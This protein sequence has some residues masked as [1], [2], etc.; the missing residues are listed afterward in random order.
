MNSTIVNN[1]SL[2]FENP[3]PE[4]RAIKYTVYVF[5][6]VFSVTG[7][8]LVILTVILFQRLKTVPNIFIAN[9]AACDL[10]T[11]ISSI[12]FDLPAEE[13]GYWPYGEFMCKI[14]WPL[15]TFSSTSAVFT[16][17]AISADRYGA[18]LHP[19]NF[20]YKI[21]RRK[22]VFVIC[23]VYFLAAVVVL[24]YLVFLKLFPPE[25]PGL[26]PQC[27]EDWPEMGLRKSYT[28]FLFVIQYGI[29]LIAMSYI[30]VRLGCLLQQNTRHAREMSLENKPL[31]PPH[32]K[33]SQLST[34][35]GSSAASQYRSSLQRRK[36]Q[37]DRTVKMFFVIVL[38][39][40][41]FML[42]N[43]ILWLLYDFGN[44]QEL[45]DHIDLVAFICRAFT[46][47][48]SVLNAT[49]YGACNISF[50]RAFKAIMYCKCGRNHQREMMRSQ[51]MSQGRMSDINYNRAAIYRS[52]TRPNSPKRGCTSPY[53]KP[54]LS[55]SI[56]GSS[57]SA[58]STPTVLAACN[59]TKRPV[60]HDCVSPKKT[61]LKT[62]SRTAEKDPIQDSNA[63][64]K[65]KM[66]N[67]NNNVQI[68]TFDE[69]KETKL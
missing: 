3:H 67:I 4:L 66:V 62:D 15:A 45:N 54:E 34:N 38:I 20:R 31:Q 65:E 30:Y 29:P 17:L 11:T 51:T 28:V 42:P 47:T 35:S 25:K 53:R 18:L 55:D 44:S 58:D 10:V 9:L 12:P 69:S 1:Q 33:I 48:N 41:I 36:E 37:N 43:Q 26:M 49:V 64:S 60:H 13:L 22:C 39:F 52:P 57:R 68:F 24:P 27:G 46:Y 56:E 59:G 5:I 7:N 2:P 50:R 14:L 32:R 19:L 21:T 63:T 6:F 23:F 40:V 8:T 16:L 61:A